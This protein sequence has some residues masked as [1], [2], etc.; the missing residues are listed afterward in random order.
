M[1]RRPLTQPKKHQKKQTTRKLR[2]CCSAATQL[3]APQ[4]QARHLLR[5]DPPNLGALRDIPLRIGNSRELTQVAD[6]NGNGLDRPG[7]G[8]KE[9]PRSE[10]KQCFGGRYGTEPET[11]LFSFKRVI[12]VDY[13]R[14]HPFVSR[15]F[16]V[17]GSGASDGHLHKKLAGNGGRDFDPYVFGA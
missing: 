7:N 12:A 9:A 11:G 13:D 15:C 14:S 3:P 8:A 16:T 1:N 6:G 5:R 4:T 10:P 2:N 17:G